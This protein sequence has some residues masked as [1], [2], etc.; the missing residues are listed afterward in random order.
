MNACTYAARLLVFALIICAV[1]SAGL[2]QTVVVRPNEMGN[3]VLAARQGTG[4][5]APVGEF[6]TLAGSPAGEGACH[7]ETFYSDTDP[8]SKIYL[9]TND[10]S[11]V[12]LS[13]ITSLKYSTYVIYRGYG[14]EG[15]PDG[16][17]PMIELITD[18]GSAAGVDYPQQRRFVY[19]PWGQ[20]GENAAKIA[21][22]TWQE[23]DLMASDGCWNVVND[24]RAA[25]SGNW[26]WLKNL[27]RP[28]TMKIATPVVGDYVDSYD[29]EW[30]LANQSGTGLSIKI[31]SGKAFERQDDGHHNYWWKESASIDGY[32]DKLT[33]GI[34]GVETTYDLEPPV[35]RTVV[36]RGANTQQAIINDAKQNFKF[37]V[38]GEVIDT[39]YYSFVTLDDGSNRTVKVLA[40]NLVV[41]PGTYV[42]ATGVLDN[43]TD[44]PSLTST[45]EQIEIL[46]DPQL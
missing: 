4:A 40:A 20:Y 26:D 25:Y 45:V 12:L 27:Y 38:F 19:K 30:R 7:I 35:I 2:A 31:G 28:G 23:W 37:T 34:S 13:S 44:P 43:Q 42:R 39:D 32:V 5:A 22:N 33:I 8:L 16:Q 18:S 41:A 6:L 10:H 46:A 9:G 15:S 17:P 1:A 24:G 36:I 3:W 21:L 29:A 11:G 14:G